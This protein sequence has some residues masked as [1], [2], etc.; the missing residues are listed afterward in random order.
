MKFKFS[1]SFFLFFSHLH[2]LAFPGLGDPVEKK[3]T[4]IQLAQSHIVVLQTDAEMIWGAYYFAVQNGTSGEQA[5]R[6]RIRLPRESIDFQAAEGLSNEDISILEDGVLSVSKTYPPGLS[7]QGIQFKVP[8]KKDSD[9]ILTFIPLEDI[10]TLFFATQQ[11]EILH[12]FAEGFEEGIPP[13]LA[14][15]QY[16]GIRGQNLEAGKVLQLR[17]TGFP[18]GRRPYFILGAFVGFFL[19]AFG[20]LLTFRTSKEEKIFS[21]LHSGQR[22]SIEYHNS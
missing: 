1:L 17:I 18:G 20:A 15:G 21:D 12:F 6:A 9:N 11:S 13:M 16:T 14:G 22:D 4:S 3:D 8:V 2:A 19:L 7:L 5:F 10:P